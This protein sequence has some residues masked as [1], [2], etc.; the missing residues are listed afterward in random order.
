MN[1]VFLDTATLDDLPDQLQRLASLGTYV[2]YSGT[3]AD[4]VVNRLTGAQVAISNKVVIDRGVMDQ[5]PDLKLICIAATGKN[6]VDLKAAEERGIPVRNVSGYSTEAVAQLTVT[7]LL[8][9]AMDLLHLNEAVYDGTYAKSPS[10][11]YWR[12]SY[13]ELSGATYGIIGLGTIGRRVAEL[14]TAFGANVIYHSTSG[15]NNDQ[16]YP[17]VSLDEL[18]TASDAVSI[19]CPLNERTEGLI[20][21]SALRKMKSG[22]YLVNVARGGVVVEADLIQALND[23]II[24][25]AACDVFTN[26]PLPNDHV[27]HTVRDRSRLLLTPHVGWASV[28]ARTLLIDGLLENIRKGY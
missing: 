8:A 17:A 15:R 25:G 2:G 20:D 16:P 28:E 22:A 18:L 6:N 4:E 21:R 23:G 12:R 13:A 5:L 24:A 14:A 9:L 19:H 7:S 1:I 27:Y 3:K 10:F 26:E 11:A